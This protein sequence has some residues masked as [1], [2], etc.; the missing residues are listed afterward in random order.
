[1]NIN[2]IKKEIYNLKEHKLKIKVI[3]RRNKY[4]YYEGKIKDIYSNIFTIETNKGLKS[5]TYSDI[6]T[7]TVILSK[8]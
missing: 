8:I 2:K 5:Y 6:A 1:M 3:M 7:K 4:E